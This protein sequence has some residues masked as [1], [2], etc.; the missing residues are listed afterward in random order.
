MQYAIL[1]SWPVFFFFLLINF[2]FK[3]KYLKLNVIFFG[4]YWVCFF[5]ISSIITFYTFAVI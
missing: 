2:N 5:F 3:N 1:F 4:W